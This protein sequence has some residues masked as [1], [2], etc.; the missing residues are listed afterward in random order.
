MDEREKVNIDLQVKPV[1]PSFVA[2]YEENEL[3]AKEE[4]RDNFV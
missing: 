2:T 4:N 3:I 1:F